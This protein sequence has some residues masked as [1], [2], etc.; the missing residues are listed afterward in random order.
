MLQCWRRTGHLPC[1]LVPTPGDL[2]AREC[3]LSE[4]C[5][6]RPKQKLMAGGQPG[7]RGGMGA[8]GIDWCR[9]HCIKAIPFLLIFIQE[10]SAL[11]ILTYDSIG[12]IIPSHRFADT[13]LAAY[14][15]G[16]RNISY[17]DLYQIRS[18]SPIHNKR[19]LNLIVIHLKL[20]SKF[21]IKF[22]Q[23]NIH[24]CFLSRTHLVTSHP[25]PTPNKHVVPSRT[26]PDQFLWGAKIDP[27]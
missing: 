12:L 27:V 3:P 8:A 1:F 17:T 22:K 19:D 18:V 26:I 16:D 14:S 6:P 4:I 15:S 9:N 25:S 7:G 10:K 11:I 2:T 21:W 20:I 23:L 5:H 13:N 24:V